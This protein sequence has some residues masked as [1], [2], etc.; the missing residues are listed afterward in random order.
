M[1]RRTGAEKSSRE[2]SMAIKKN[3]VFT[4]LHSLLDFSSFEK[5]ISQKQNKEQQ[6]LQSKIKL[7]KAIIYMRLRFIWY[8]ICTRKRYIVGKSLGKGD[9][10]LYKERGNSMQAKAAM[11]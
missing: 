3:T 4:P 11:F 5:P 6:K 2:I 1:A 8:G 10:I 9:L 7:L